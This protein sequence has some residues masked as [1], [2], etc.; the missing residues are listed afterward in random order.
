MRIRAHGHRCRIQRGKAVYRKA[1]KSMV[2]SELLTEREAEIVDAG[3][4]TD[5]ASPILE[6]G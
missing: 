3:K 1:V 4:L 2:Q 5:F 6:E